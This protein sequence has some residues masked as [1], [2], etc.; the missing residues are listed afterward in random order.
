M[1]IQAFEASEFIIRRGL[2]HVHVVE[3]LLNPGDFRA[4]EE[5][6]DA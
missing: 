6:I 3:F 1:I 5:T 2:E 4:I